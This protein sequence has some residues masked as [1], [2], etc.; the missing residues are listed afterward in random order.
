M[1]DNGYIVTSVDEYSRY[2][3][4]TYRSINAW[5]TDLILK[6]EDLNILQDVMT[7]AGELNQRVPCNKIVNSEFAEKDM[8]N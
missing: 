4:Y 2:I 3:P 1:Q 5:A 7:E 6:E 8:K